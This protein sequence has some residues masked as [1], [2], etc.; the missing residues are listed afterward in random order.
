[1]WAFWKFVKAYRSN[2]TDNFDE[3]L[4]AA[5]DLMSKYSQPLFRGYVMGFLEQKSFEAIRKE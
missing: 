5:D 2:E 4:K 1:M 3:A